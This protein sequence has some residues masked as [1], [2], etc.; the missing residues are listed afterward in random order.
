MGPRQHRK[1]SPKADLGAGGVA[2]SGKWRVSCFPPEP[3]RSPHEPF[4]QLQ[5]HQQTAHLRVAG[6]LVVCEGRAGTGALRH[7]V[8]ESRVTHEGIN[9]RSAHGAASGEHQRAIGHQSTHRRSKGCRPQTGSR[10]N[11]GAVTTRPP[12]KSAPCC[13]CP[14]R[15]VP[16]RA[17]TYIGPSWIDRKKGSASGVRPPCD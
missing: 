14:H 4:P 12:L 16:Q 3:S 7:H 5:A 11:R 13:S 15:R 8:R 6:M 2:A 17:Q 10:R 9:R 1:H